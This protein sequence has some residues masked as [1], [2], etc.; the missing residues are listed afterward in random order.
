MKYGKK[1][2]AE[3][4]AWLE[5]VVKPGDTV[6]TVVRHVSRSGMSRRIDLYTIK[7]GEM[8]YLTG[9]VACLL[10]YSRA[11]GSNH[12]LTVVGCGMDMG[13]HLVYNLAVSLFCPEKYDH[14]KAYSLTHRWI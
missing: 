2:V 6:Y 12:G 10:G 3:S 5:G 9:H 1:E 8:V 7:G 4:R 11:G 14:D 13:F